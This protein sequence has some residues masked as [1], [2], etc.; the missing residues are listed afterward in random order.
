MAQSVE[1]QT[2]AQVM[3]SPCMSLG[4]LWGLLLSVQSLLWILCP[5]LS[6]PSLL[7]L[8]LS[9]KNI[10]TFKIRRRKRK[11]K[12]EKRRIIER[13]R[14]QKGLL[15]KM[16]VVELKISQNLD[17]VLIH[18]STGIYLTSIILWDR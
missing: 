16:K 1:H 9:L 8:S 10:L 14:S 13:L 11:K 18:C 6:V 4:F 3:M 15:E 17:R 12:S 2:L 5:P 7:V